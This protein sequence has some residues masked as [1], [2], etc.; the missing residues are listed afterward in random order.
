VA[1]DAPVVLD[2]DDRVPSQPRDLD[3]VRHLQDRWN[4]STSVDRLL[5]ALA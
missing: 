5:E 4:L 1:Q 2:R 3:R